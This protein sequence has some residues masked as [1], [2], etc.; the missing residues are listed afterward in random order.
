MTGSAQKP[1]APLPGGRVSVGVAVVGGGHNGV[2]AA[3]YLAKSGLRVTVVEASD[4]PGGMTASGPLIAAA[5]DH[6]INSCAV[7]IISMLHSQVPRD[8]DLRNFGLTIT[9]PDPSYVALHPAGATLALWRDAARPAADIE[10]FS[11]ADA[12][13]F[14][15]FMR[16]LDGVITTV[17]PLMGTDTARPS[18]SVLL[19]TAREVFRSRRDLS[20]ITALV[21]GSASSAVAGRFSSPVV[22]GALLNPPRGA[23]PLGP[24]RRGLG[25]LPLPPPSPLGARRPVR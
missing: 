19:H 22:A 14:P 6:V 15:E 20:E 24:P 3:C 7:D 8:L 25:F 18:A 10:Q 21:T 9:K 2:V 16:L 5:P 17:L 1:A 12:R 4:L 11:R 23:R 13:E